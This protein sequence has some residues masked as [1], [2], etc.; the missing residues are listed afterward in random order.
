MRRREPPQPT[1]TA[2]PSSNLRKYGLKFLPRHALKWIAPHPILTFVP[3]NWDPQI[4]LSPCWPTM[5]RW[6]FRK[7][8]GEGSAHIQ[9]TH[10]ITLDLL[11][12]SF[13]WSQISYSPCKCHPGVGDLWS[14]YFSALHP[15]ECEDAAKE[16]GDDGADGE[17]SAGV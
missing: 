8:L 17:C 1:N 3:W 7:I 4:H 5:N 2:A 10:T 16:T 9:N 14:T 12:L 11:E 13:T 15:Y 6:S